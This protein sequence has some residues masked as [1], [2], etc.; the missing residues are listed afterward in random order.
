MLYNN[1]TS[2]R[3]DL[4][5][6]KM[7]SF[8]SANSLSDITFSLYKSL[9]VFRSSKLLRHNWAYFIGDSFDEIPVEVVALFG[10]VLGTWDAR[11]VCTKATAASTSGSE[12]LLFLFFLPPEESWSCSNGIGGT[13]S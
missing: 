10:D 6:L 3:R 7:R 8:S 11:E 2:H 13:L 1:V 4:R 5:V 12:R 9:S